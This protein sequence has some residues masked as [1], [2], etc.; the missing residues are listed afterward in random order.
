METINCLIFGIIKSLFQRNILMLV[1]I[2]WQLKKCIK[3]FYKKYLNK[4]T[5]IYKM[6]DTAK[7]II[8][9]IFWFF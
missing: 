1:L 8:S 2:V 6:I 5:T 9:L 7:L 3:L 4:L